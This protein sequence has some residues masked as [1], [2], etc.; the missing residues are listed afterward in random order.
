MEKSQLEIIFELFD[1]NKDGRISK[2]DIRKVFNLVESY[3]NR[4]ESFYSEVLKEVDIENTGSVNVSHFLLSFI[5]FCV[6]VS[7]EAIPSSGRSQRSN[8]LK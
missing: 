8:L 6:L 3:R 1:R 5:L 4:P 7:S 2:E